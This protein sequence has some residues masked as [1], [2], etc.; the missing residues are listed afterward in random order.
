MLVGLQTRAARLAFLLAKSSG[1]ADSFTAAKG[2]HAAMQVLFNCNSTATAA[3]HKTGEQSTV[4]VLQLTVLRLL[5]RLA[6]CSAVATAVMAREKQLMDML[7]QQL[8]DAGAAA[9]AAAAPGKGK[10]AAEKS[11]SES[12]VMPFG[13]ALHTCISSALA[14]TH[15]AWLHDVNETLLES[16]KVCI[17]CL[18]YE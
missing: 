8:L 4:A 18:F 17:G 1:W 7:M 6:G 16:C 12:K 13:R 14:V 5:L 10:P 15:P 3:G 2:V 9:A 11:T